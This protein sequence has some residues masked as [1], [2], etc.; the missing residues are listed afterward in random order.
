MRRFAIVVGLAA[1]LCA[2]GEGGD[3][4]GDDVSEVAAV[5]RF[6][7]DVDAARRGGMLA[8]GI[9]EDEAEIART[10]EVVRTRL[11]KLDLSPSRLARE[12]RTAFRVSRPRRIS[13]D[14]L[15][16]VV[17]AFG[18]LEFRIEVLPDVRYRQ[19]DRSEARRRLR[20]WAGAGEGFPATPEGFDAFRAAEADVWRRARD[21]GT[22]Y[23]PT[24]PRYRLARRKDTRGEAPDDFAV[25]EEPRDAASRF[26][27][28]TL[29]NVQADV[30]ETGL[31]CVT[32]E[33]KGD[34]QR[35][36]AAW[37][38]ENVQ[39]PMAIVLDGEYDSAPYIQSALRD[40]VQITLGGSLPGDGRS[41]I[42][43]R[44]RILA[45]V[46]SVG[47]VRIPARFLGSDPAPGAR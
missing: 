25:L 3:G 21:A 38:G 13:E 27:S 26:G 17:T 31:P 44:A 1:A 8:P 7:L 41:V 19:D 40:R 10:L 22:A 32:Y 20:V 36:F 11:R 30:D 45:T 29:T 5:L 14:D 33:V 2:C 34:F 35:A 39:M 47:S 46:L 18:T 24:D 28:A 9:F 12:G 15:A 37:T 42:D 23:V 43:Q 6:E 16:R 4:T